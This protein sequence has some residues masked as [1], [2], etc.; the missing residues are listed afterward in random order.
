MAVYDDVMREFWIFQQQV[1][2][3]LKQC[4][5]LL[6]IYNGRSMIIFWLLGLRLDGRL[7]FD[8][9]LLWGGLILVLAYGWASALNFVDDIEIDRV[10]RRKNPLLSNRIGARA[11]KW[12]AGGCGGLSL[13]LAM[14]ME[15]RWW[16]VGGTLILLILGWVYSRGKL[17]HRPM[18]KIGVMVLGYALVPGMMGLQNWNLNLI[19]VLMS[20]SMVYG[21]W[22]LYA[23]VKDIKGDRKYG[24]RTL[25]VVWGVKR[26]VILSWGLGLVCSGVSW[27]LMKGQVNGWLGWG[28][29]AGLLVIAQT[30]VVWNPKLLS[31]KL[32]VRVG[33]YLL[34]GWYGWLL[35]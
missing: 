28:G 2:G 12:L 24:K 26:L 30:M 35:L 22:M 4:M 15:E 20:L 27:Y 18:G 17:A 13:G 21:A 1:R 3:W 33:G 32:T 34:L 9:Q 8:S 31:Q 16:W 7:K 29:W 19:G 5:A 23:D 14:M 6:R 11:A 25:A 10:N